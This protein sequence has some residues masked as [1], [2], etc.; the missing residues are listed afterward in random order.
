LIAAMNHI[1]RVLEDDGYK[2][3]IVGEPRD[4]VYQI[5]ISASIGLSAFVA[6]CV[7]PLAQVDD[8]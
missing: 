7:R 6:F 2:K 5:I 1:F 3:H 8:G 4:T